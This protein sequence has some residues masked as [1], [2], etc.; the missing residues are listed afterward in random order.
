VQIVFQNPY[1]SLDPR[2][3]VEAIVAEP[4]LAGGMRARAQR[5]ERVVGLLRSVGLDSSQLE[6]FPHQFSGGQRQRIGLARALALSPR[7][8]V[9]D[10]PTSALDVSVQA[11]ILQL[12]KQIQDQNRLSIL[13]ISHNLAVVKYLCDRVGVLYSGRLVE[14]GRAEALFAAPLHPYTEALLQAVP[15]PRPHPPRVRPLEGESPSPANPPRGCRLHPR[16]PKAKA[17]GMPPICSEQEPPLRDAGAGHLVACHFVRVAGPL[18]APA[19][20]GQAAP[21]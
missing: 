6:R 12:L 7:L 1:A 16:C 20:I 5:R 2:M 4:L 8:L 11:Q 18:A 21:G 15:E 19:M 9:A 3:T 13:L 17:L 14:I 10:E